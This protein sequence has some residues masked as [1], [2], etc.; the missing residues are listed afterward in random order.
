M[1]KVDKEKIREEEK[2]KKEKERIREEKKKKEKEKKR[3]KKEKRK[4]KKE[5]RK[6]LK[7]KEKSE[8]VLRAVGSIEDEYD[9]FRYREKMGELSIRE[10]LRLASLLE[11]IPKLRNRFSKCKKEKKIPGF[12]EFPKRLTV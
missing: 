1:F 2:K 5:H 10:E 8:T 4:K 7:G 9:N 12:L 6:I 3:K 11:T